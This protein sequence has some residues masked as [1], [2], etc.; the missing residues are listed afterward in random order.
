LQADDEGGDDDNN[1]DTNDD[2]DDDDSNMM[3]MG[4][5]V[6]MM[7]FSIP[8]L[9]SPWLWLSRKLSSFRHCILLLSTCNTNIIINNK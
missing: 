2:G 8:R 1:D 5:I 3:I 7:I 9:V 4:A 6:I